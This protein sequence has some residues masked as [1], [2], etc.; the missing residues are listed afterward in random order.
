MGTGKLISIM[1]SGVEKW[2]VLIWDV[3]EHAVA[4]ILALVFTLYMVGKIH[5]LYPFLFIGLFLW[6]FYISRFFNTK[7]VP[8]RFERN[9]NAIN[10]SKHVVKVIMSK[11]EV[12]Q[13]DKIQ[14]ENEKI[15]RLYDRDIS[16]NQYMGTHR[17]F[18]TRNSGFSIAIL[19]ILSYYFLGYWYLE[20]RVELSILVGL[21]GTLIVIQKV[22]YE[23]LSFY[24][25]FTK[26]FVKVTKLWDF[27]DAT[28]EI[29]WYDDGELFQYK[30]GTIE[31]KDIS[32]WYGENKNIFDHFN[33]LVAG[34]KITAFV[35][36]SGGGKSTLVKIISQ[37]IK[38][39]SGSLYIDGQDL[40]TVSLKSY[41]QNIGYLTQEPSIF[42]GTIFEN[43]TYSLHEDM[44]SPELL[45]RMHQ[46]IE[47]AKCEFIYDLQSWLDTQIGERGV[48]L[49]GWQKQRLAIAKIMLKDPHIIILDE[50]TSALDSFSE[51]LITKAMNNLFNWRTVLIIAHRLQTVRHAD[52]IIVIEGGQVIERG[53]HARLI[54][55][56]GIYARMLELQSGF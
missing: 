41:Y 32:F 1:G 10:I 2:G 56:N 25:D 29:L 14:I 4:L 51:D 27:F 12:L 54:T 15:D 40:S 47:L 44:E 5:P 43:L 26:E 23:N 20:W 7:M 19:L 48:R 45:N 36:N 17:A 16:I 9:D 6:F 21:S 13:S 38:Q 39:D 37:Y 30:N 35:W 31:L 52:D 34:G 46:I 24:I 3:I 28:P 33:L 8:Y 55:Q 49:S 22:I 50:P 18:L 53:N 11:N 42:D